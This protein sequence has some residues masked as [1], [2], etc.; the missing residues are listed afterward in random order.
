MFSEFDDTMFPDIHINLN[1]DNINYQGFHE[2]TQKWESY[3]ERNTPYTFIFTSQGSAGLKVTNYIKSIVVF[4]KKL[5]KKKKNYNNV[6]L[7]KSIII[8]KNNFL[9]YLLK[10]IFSLQKPLAPV[11]IIDN[12]NYITKLCNS[13]VKHPKLYDSHVSAYFP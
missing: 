13:I 3:D 12:E 6:F 9:K 11:Y 1:L 8:C 5:K 2:F 10:C 4:I 7:S